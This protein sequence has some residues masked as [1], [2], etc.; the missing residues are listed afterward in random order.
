MV[1]FCAPVNVFTTFVRLRTYATSTMRSFSS[2]SYDP[3]LN[4]G[5]QGTPSTLITD[6]SWVT[7]QCSCAYIITVYTNSLLAASLSAR[8]KIQSLGSS[9]RSTDRDTTLR[10]YVTETACLILTTFHPAAGQHLHKDRQD[11]KRV[12]A[13]R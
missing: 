1:D 4:T 13:P 6:H 9:F 11:T 3:S 7:A 8:K 5:C 12:L 2:D 10:R